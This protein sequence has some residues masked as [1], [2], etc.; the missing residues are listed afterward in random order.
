MTVGL[1]DYPKA[2]IKMAV[3]SNTEGNL[4]LGACHKEPWTVAWIERMAQGSVFYDVGANVGSY[5]LLAASRGMHVYA[6]EPMSANMARLEQNVGLNSYGKL[7]HA[8][9]VALG[10]YDG[11]GEIKFCEFTPGVSSLH[12]KM[13]PNVKTLLTLP[14]LFH[15]IDTLVS[16]GFPAP[17]YLKVDVE[18]GEAKVLAGA[19]QCLMGEQF[20]G[21]MVEVEENCRKDIY[22]QMKVCGL[23]LKQEYTQREFMTMTGLAKVMPYA[24]FVPPRLKYA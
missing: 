11:L 6:F 7:I 10:D 18:D 13:S 4:R 2:Q 20:K 8:F 16:Y 15:Q 14:V 1:L 3:S 19:R 12:P 24:E 5:S 21:L 23:V 17:E 9:G 22:D